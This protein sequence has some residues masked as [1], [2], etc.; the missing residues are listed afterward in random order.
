[1]KKLLSAF[2]VVAALAVSPAFAAVEAGKAAPEFAFKDIK[3]TEHKISGFKGK[4]L[5]LEWTNPGCPFV[6]KFYNGGDMQ[7]F[8]S[9]ALKDSN[10]VWVSVNSSADGKEGS[11]KD[12]AEAQ[13]FVT[14]NKVASTAYVRDNSGAFG[15]LYDAKTTPYFVIVNKDGNVAYAGAIDSIK[16]TDA[17]DIVKADN[18]VTAALASLAK[19][20][21]PKTQSTESYGCGV[22]YAD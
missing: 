6:K 22:K 3:G 12:D 18:Y 15:K 2:A 13:K 14:D 7:K 17:A 1:M 5:V 11:F 8:Q 10:V 4:T 19:G 20:E 21:T 9:E 16:S